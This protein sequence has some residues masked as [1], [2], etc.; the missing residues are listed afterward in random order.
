MSDLLH[1][2]KK[3]KYFI[4]LPSQEFPIKT[5]QEIVKILKIYN[6]ANDIEG[7]T[8]SRALQNRY[9]FRYI[10]KHVD[11][12]VK[13]KIYKTKLTKDDPPYNITVVKGS[14][15]GV[16]SRAF[17]EYVTENRVARELL[18]WFRDV[19]SPDEYYWATLHHNPH[20][21][22]PGAYKGKGM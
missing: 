6:G 3:W 11:S 21:G 19:L 20:I 7:I 17:V 15:Y 22:T 10:Y 18:D 2:G 9:K 14:A 13:P 8:G 12:Q 1:R 5:N 4:N 16:F